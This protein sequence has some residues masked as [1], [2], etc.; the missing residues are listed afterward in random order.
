M[1]TRM[2]RVV[3]VAVGFAGLYTFADTKKNEVTTSPPHLLA[4][5]PKTEGA[6]PFR[7]G[8]RTMKHYFITG[9]PASGKGTQT[10]MLLQEYP[11][12][13]HVSSGD[14]FRAEIRSG[15]ELGQQLLSYVSAGTLVPEP[16]AIKPVLQAV[17]AAPGRVILD[18]YPR[19]LEAA[20]LLKQ[21]G[22]EP[23]VVFV[24]NV[25]PEVVRARVHGRLLD[26]LTGDTYHKLFAP[27]PPD[28]AA[29][30]EKRVDDTTKKLERRLKVWK[31]T[32]AA[33]Q[34]SYSAYI[35]EVDGSKTIA[36]VS[37]EI[38]SVVAALEMTETLDRI[39][40]M[41]SALGIKKQ[42]ND[43]EQEECL[44]QPAVANA[45]GTAMTEDE[46]MIK[47]TLDRIKQ[48]ESA[49]GIKEQI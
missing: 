36:E 40:Q 22:V 27:P 23:A 45:H 26:P 12:L 33:I 9:P 41:E 7:S 42:I 29:R 14:L 20:G 8:D 6:I 32:R 49:L 46:K 30:C 43:E 3:G 19:S 10:N 18:G 13:T 38:V 37:A 15:S 34:E 2:T 24:L 25:S 21:N 17:E 5:S 44:S 4:T 48:I 39:K 28:I 31:G 1:F 35:V 16:I 11:H 47:E